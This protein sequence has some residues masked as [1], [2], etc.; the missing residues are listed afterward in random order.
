MTTRSFHRARRRR[1]D[2]AA[3][4][5]AVLARRGR[6]LAG[7]TL[8]ATT[9]L[10]ANAQAATYVVNTTADSTDGSCG[11]PCSLRDAIIAANADGTTDTITFAPSVTGTIDL[12]S[13][14]PITSQHGLTIQGPGAG[15][16]TISGQG[17]TG[18]FKITSSGDP[19]S[20]PNS[21]SGLTLTKG[22][23][24]DPGG[25]VSDQSLVPLALT[26]DVITKS[27]STNSD[28]Q[29]GGGGV[30]AEGPT[31]I[32]SSTIS[33]N[34]AAHGGGVEINPAY[35]GSSEPKYGLTL[36]IERSTIAD[37]HALDGSSGAGPVGGGGGVAAYGSELVVRNST[38][39]GNTSAGSGGGIADV[40]KYGLKV[41]QSTLSG[42]TANDLGGGISD[43]G[44]IGGKKYDP[45]EI[46][47]S[48][49]SGNKAQFGAGVG[50]VQY[51]YGPLTS[52]G[53]PGEPVTIEASTISRNHG[54]PPRTGHGRSFGG[55][56][57]VFGSLASPFRLVD[58]TVSGNT[59]DRGGGVD[60]GVPYEPLFA[61]DPTT[62]EKGS[63]SLENSTIAGNTANRFHSGGG[64]Y[65]AGYTP[66]GGGSKKSGNASLEST[67]VAGNRSHGVPNDLQ[68]AAASTTGGFKGAF[69]LVQF[70]ASAPL[71]GSH[72]ILGKNPQLGPLQN[73]GGPTQ[74]MEPSGTSPVIDQGHAGLGV[75]TDQRG[76]PR[77]VDSAIP[78]PPTGDGTDIGAVELSIGQVVPPPPTGFAARVGGQLL[79]G[80]STPLLIDGVTKVTC[81]VKVGELGACAIEVTSHGRT[82]AAGGI[83]S[84]NPRKRLTTTV[85]SSRAE[86]RY[87][88]E[89][90]PLGVKASATAVGL[91][92]GPASDVGPV[93][94]LGGPT[95]TLPLGTGT[96]NFSQKVNGELDRAASLLAGAT[97]VTLTSDSS[98]QAAAVS[99][100]LAKDGVKAKIQ[101]RVSSHA[102]GHQI[103]ITF[104]Y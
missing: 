59:A 79:G 27:T 87:L 13:A 9:L 30:F 62:G 35:F 20:N 12:G 5:A 24:S 44:W 74:T 31:A 36:T 104:R 82:L 96:T 49:I 98:T 29:G 51:T 102:P 11:S 89:H 94:L 47:A 81:S 64:V 71:T 2:R 100:R 40:S 63:V 43:E 41:S 72:L 83:P 1:L 3:R 69:S 38:V 52:G 90:F 21:I 70:P 61:T 32:I 97:E 55:G 103:T 45:T 18:I 80:S 33:G 16:L 58:S 23:T 10:A 53:A 28:S 34:T 50:I 99:K 8:G 60:L 57:G 66:S 65:L 73:N 4:R 91:A 48:T 15:S 68:R 6:L 42:N 77:T 46:S 39:S 54:T 78:N 26:N 95:I 56:L 75:S 22:S 92:S 67:I 76:D 7:A 25:A 88:L 93:T 101:I 86:Q 17:S 19:L 85:N 14:L 37:N 84:N